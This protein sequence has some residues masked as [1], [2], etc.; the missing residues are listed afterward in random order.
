[1]IMAKTFRLKYPDVWPA[2]YKLGMWAWVF[3]RVTALF[4]IGYGLIH[5]LE[6]MV[7]H[8]GSDVFDAFFGLGYTW[9][10]QTLD[11]LLM[12]AL[13]FHSMNGLRIILFDLGIGIR[14]HKL[15]FTL[16]MIAGLALYCFVAATI[17]PYIIGKP[18]F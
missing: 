18:L 15:G 11:L 12:A 13:L 10:M 1:M 16:T 4:I 7:S 8:F 9:W 3:H 6:V 14:H 17:L 5:L 2:S